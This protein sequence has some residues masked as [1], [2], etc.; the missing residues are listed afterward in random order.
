MNTDTHQSTPIHDF[1]GLSYANYLVL[2]RTLLQSCSAE[3]QRALCDA[4]ERVYQEEKEHMSHHWPGPARIE[5]QLRDVA[6]GEF[7]QDNLSNYERGRRRLWECPEPPTEKVT[8]TSPK[9]EADYRVGVLVCGVCG[10]QKD[11]CDC[12]ELPSPSVKPNE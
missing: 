4:L 11:F 5:V 8:S 6:T 1:F 3:T 12:G 10:Y 7:I 2:P 9:R